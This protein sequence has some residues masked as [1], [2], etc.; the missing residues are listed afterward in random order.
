MPKQRLS[1][2][3][4]PTGRNGDVAAARKMLES[5]R[6]TNEEVGKAIIGSRDKTLAILHRGQQRVIVPK[7]MIGDTLHA[8][9]VTADGSH[10]IN[11]AIADLDPAAR[12]RLLPPAQRPEQHAMRAMLALAA[13]KTTELNRAAPNTGPLKPLLT[14]LEP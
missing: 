4:I 9:L 3:A 2:A 5:L 6:R 7:F 11:F 13:G 12:L 1:A 14:P 10:R 8:D